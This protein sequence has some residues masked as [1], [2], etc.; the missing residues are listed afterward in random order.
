MH[1]AVCK[2]ETQPSLP[3]TLAPTPVHHSYSLVLGC[4]QPRHPCPTGRVTGGAGGRLPF[5]S[6][7][8]AQHHRASVPSCLK[9]KFGSQTPTSQQN[10]YTVHT[11][12]H[13]GLWASWYYSCVCASRGAVSGELRHT[14]SF[15]QYLLPGPLLPY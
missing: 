13:L 14:F 10:L 6:Y 4:S 1:P 15:G 11:C 9:A 5:P 7:L 3:S 8:S 12:R 2:V